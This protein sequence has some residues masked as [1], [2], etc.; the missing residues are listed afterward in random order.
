MGRNPRR[1]QPGHSQ[2]PETSG[3]PKV[4]PPSCIGD[5]RNLQ[6]G[7]IPKRDLNGQCFFGFYLEHIYSLQLDLREKIR[8]SRR[9]DRPPRRK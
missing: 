9:P 3:S 4:R 1:P 8:K 7:G 5:L 6:M 2:E